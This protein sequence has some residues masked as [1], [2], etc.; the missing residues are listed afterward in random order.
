MKEEPT[1]VRIPDLSEEEKN[2]I[3]ASQG[4][5]VTILLV[6][7]HTVRNKFYRTIVR[8]NLCFTHASLGLPFLRFSLVLC[9]QFTPQYSPLQTFFNYAA[10]VIER[11][12]AEAE[13]VSEFRVNRFLCQHSVPTFQVD[14]FIDYARD[15]H[16]EV[17]ASSDRL[18]LSRV[19]SDPKWSQNR[20]VLRYEKNRK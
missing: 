3:V 8:R 13:D 20:Y 7:M 18:V 15:G 17:I 14:I 9:S 4:F 12:L 10:K 19:F 1:P 6:M 5:Q 16:G 11:A 2:Q